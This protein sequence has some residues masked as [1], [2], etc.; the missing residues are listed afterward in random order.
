MVLESFCNKTEHIPTITAWTQ[1]AA[2]ICAPDDFSPNNSRDI[3]LLRIQTLQ[4]A[5]NSNPMRTTDSI[6]AKKMEDA[7]ENCKHN[8]DSAGGII[9]CLITGIPAGLGEPV[10]DKLDAE[11]AKAI[12]SIGAVKGIEFGSGF[13]SA[14]MHG[15][16]WND[17]MAV[18]QEHK[19]FFTTNHSGGILGGLS[20]GAPILFDVAVKPVPSIRKTQK[21][22]K[23]NK[24]TNTFENTC[25]SIEGRHDVCLCPRIIPVVEA[26]ATI[27]LADMLLRNYTAR[28]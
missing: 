7:I 16:E 5:I 24:S 17:S 21:T 14:Q 9:R 12:L 18:E 10:F 13:K 6:S 2:G 8:K 1:E 22:I 20:T 19:P 3:S 26:M 11:L 4:T 27:V 23:K 15:S 25:I 28:R